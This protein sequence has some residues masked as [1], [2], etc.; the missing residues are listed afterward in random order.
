M[1]TTGR[2]TPVRSDGELE[3][4]PLMASVLPKAQ[5]AR[6]DALMHRLCKRSGFPLAVLVFVG[7]QLRRAVVP[8]ATLERDGDILNAVIVA[9]LAELVRHGPPPFS[10]L[11]ER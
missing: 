4:R 3:R 10:D 7:A 8:A 1:V 2:R 9:A 6:A 5:L 11:S